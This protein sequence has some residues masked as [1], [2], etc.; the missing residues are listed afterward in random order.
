VTPSPS[1]TVAITMLTTGVASNPT[2]S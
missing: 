1:Q 2:R